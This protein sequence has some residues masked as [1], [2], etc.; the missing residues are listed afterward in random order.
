MSRLIYN[1]MNHFSRGVIATFILLF[2]SSFLFA[3]ED[4][5]QYST[6]R[7]VILSSK[8]SIVEVE[9]KIDNKKLS[10]L[11]PQGEYF[12]FY[13]NEIK[14]NVGGYDGSLLDGSY[15]V[16]SSNG[17]LLKK[18]NFKNGLKDGLWKYWYP[19]GVKAK[20]EEWENGRLNGLVKKWDKK[21][22]IKSQFDYK[23]GVKHGKYVLYDSLERQAETGRMKNGAKHGKVLFFLNGKLQSKVKYRSG[24]KHGW[25]KI[26]DEAGNLIYKQRYRNGEL[27]PKMKKEDK[28]EEIESNGIKWKFWIKDES[29]NGDSN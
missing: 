2:I 25:S 28:E 12:W 5:F 16:K 27:I 14:M 18:G 8:D 11:N 7:K 19:N 22:M 3:Q 24:E 13:Q 23:E 20:A 29:S 4:D 9:L 21:G 17:D 26:Y 15:T 1:R 6:N 10:K